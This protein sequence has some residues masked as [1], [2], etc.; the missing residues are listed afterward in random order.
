MLYVILT[1][2]DIIKTKLTFEANVFITIKL[3]N[4]I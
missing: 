2:I 1:V 3:E 4:N